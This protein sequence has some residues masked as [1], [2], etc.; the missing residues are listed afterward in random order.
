MPL[1]FTDALIL[2]AVIVPPIALAIAFL[3]LISPAG[4]HRTEQSQTPTAKA[5]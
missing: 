5:H 4:L 2:G 3:Y 1:G